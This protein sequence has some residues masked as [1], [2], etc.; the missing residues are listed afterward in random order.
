MKFVAL[1]TSVAIVLSVLGFSA[2][3]STIVTTNNQFAP[4]PNQSTFTPTYDP[5]NTSHDVL[6]NATPSASS[7][8][9]TLEST[10]GTAA[11]TDGVFGAIGQAMT[12]NNHSIFATVGNGSGAGTSLTYTF[13]PTQLANIEVYGG[14]NDSGRDQQEYNVA[15]STNGVTF[16]SLTPGGTSVAS[17][18]D[19]PSIPDNSQSA[20]E[21]IFTDSSGLLAGGALI[22]ALQ[23]NFNFGVE[24]GYVGEAEIVANSPVPEPSSVVA[25]CGLGAMGLFMAVRRRRKA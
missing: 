7:G 10:G 13:T 2:Q 8:S 19:N 16:I 21:A 25:L 4:T 14:W 24:N 12:A 23:F 5:I 9:F 11:L 22:D 3:A 1:L 15:Y 6:L 17:V 18:T 20:V